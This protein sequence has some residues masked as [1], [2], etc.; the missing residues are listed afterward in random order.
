MGL[1]HDRGTK[2]SCGG[3]GYNY[4]Y[5][6]PQSELRSIMGYSCANGGCDISNVKSC[7]R[8]PRFS[9]IEYNYNGKAIGKSDANNAKVL[10]DNRVIVANYR[11]TV[12]T[13]SACIESNKLPFK[14]I[15]T[16]DRF[17]WETTWTVTDDVGTTVLSGGPYSSDDQY[18]EIVVEDCLP[19]SSY[20]FTIN[21]SW[22]DGICCSWGSGDYKLYW[23]DVLSGS[24]GDFGSTE[25]ITFGACT[26]LEGWEGSWG[27]SCS[28]IEALD[29]PGCD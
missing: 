20:T 28:L 13:G 23:N 27:I 6:D 10:N 14:L 9:N 26:D 11:P 29:N 24:G 15:L 2:N 7:P 8:V 16:L 25:S 18:T 3:S 4:G 19:D 21:D 1:L 12:N 5:R 17:P 22:G